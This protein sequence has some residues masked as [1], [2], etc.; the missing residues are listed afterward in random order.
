MRDVMHIVGNMLFLYIFGNNVKTSCGRPGY[1]AFYLAGGIFAGVADI[2]LHTG[3]MMPTLGGHGSIS[4]V[5]ARIS[6]FCLIRPSRFIYF[7]YLIGTF[8][9]SGLWFVVA[10]FM[11][12]VIEQFVGMGL[13]EKHDR[14][15]GEYRREH[16]RI[17]RLHGAAECAIVAAQYVGYV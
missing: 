12:D 3:P 13:R 16:V 1:L 4:A 6:C 10:F 7:F 15:H 2:V 8:E 11:L 17:C 5:T 9:L 14:A